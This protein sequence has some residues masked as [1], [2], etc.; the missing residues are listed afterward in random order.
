MNIEIWFITYSIIGRIVV[1]TPVEKVANSIHNSCSSAAKRQSYCMPLSVHD[2]RQF[3][4][5]KISHLDSITP[6]CQ[7]QVL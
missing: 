7:F 6:S 4:H 5:R 3:G 2:Y 1:S